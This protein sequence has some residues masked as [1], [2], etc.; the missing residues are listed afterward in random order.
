MTG[1]KITPQLESGFTLVELIIVIV[2]TG[3]LV[4]VVGPLIGGK[5]QSVSD[6]QQRAQWVQQA[7]FA[8][9]HIRQDAKRAVPNS[10]RTREADTSGDDQVVEFLTLGVTERQPVLRYRDRN[11]PNYN[12]LRLNNEDAFDVFGPLNLE[13]DNLAVSVGATNVSDL[14]DDWNNRNTSTSG[15]VARVQNVEARTDGGTGCD[16]GDCS[17][18]PVTVITLN[19]GNGNHSF[20]NH[21]PYYRVYFTDGPVGYQCDGSGQLLRHSGYNDLS[22][23]SISS[24]QDAGSTS[25]RVLDDVVGCAFQWQPGSAYRPP[26]LTVRLTLGEGGESVQLVDTIVLRNGL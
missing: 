18:N 10:V 7:E 17:Q 20:P 15:F 25:S 9:F 22:N 14:Y 3:I 24:R 12:R 16:Q 23:A 19:T 6:S 4:A 5:Y 1:S 26:T 2:V 11:H 13:L 8:L 21:S